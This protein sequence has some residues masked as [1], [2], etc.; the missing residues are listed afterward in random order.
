MVHGWGG[1][2]G[3]FLV[4]YLPGDLSPVLAEETSLLIRQVFATLIC[5]ARDGMEVSVGL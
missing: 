1:E 4:Y 5:G 2:R 3:L